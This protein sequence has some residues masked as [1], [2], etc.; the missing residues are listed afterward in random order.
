MLSSIRIHNLAVVAAAEL[1]FSNG[2]S[3]M[4]GETGA[5]KSILVDA[6]A[7]ALGARAEGRLVRTGAERAEVAAIFDR[8]SLP[9]DALNWLAEQD[10]DT[11]EDCVVRRTLTA[12]GRS[13]G[14]INGQ[15]VTM[16]SLREIGEKLVDICGQQAYLGLRHPAAQ[17]ELLDQFGGHQ[18]E[19]GK[20]AAGFDAWRRHQTALEDHDQ[21][22]RD[23]EQHMDLLSFQCQEL[24]G[25][26]LQTGEYAHLQREHRV[27]AASQRIEAGLGEVLSGLYEGESASAQD[28]LARCE[29][30]LSSLAETDPELAPTAG[31]LRDAGVLVSEAASAVRDQLNALEHDPEREEQIGQRLA[32]ARDLARK[33]RTEPEELPALLDELTEQLNKFSS[34]AEQR[35]QLV[36]QLAADA[37]ALKS[38][39]AKLSRARKKA[40][41]RLGKE[42]TAQMHDL[43]MPGGEFVVQLPARDSS[44]PSPHGAEGVAFQVTTNPGQ[45]PGPLAKVASG[46]EL[47]R[48]SLALQVAAVSGNHTG[49]LVFDEVDTGV[50]G[51]VAE[52][53]GQQLRALGQ[54]AQVL[55]VTH[56]PQ[57]ASQG[58]HHFLVS[59]QTKA[60]E[61]STA[62]EPLSPAQRVEELARM[63]GGLKIT[64][65]TREHAQEMLSA[66]K[67]RKA[68]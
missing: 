25:L 13:R 33:H 7:L 22:N 6:L 67:V 43:G 2:F 12:E 52:L 38:A 37:A 57:V 23:R 18:R 64:S 55:C 20:V 5:G 42:V 4:T 44:D 27:L 61:T 26:A 9:V 54:N 50:G 24:S 30:Q 17:R 32:D 39:A 62:V 47:S 21:A 48:L 56:L 46:G 49:T 59:K 65:R 35:E 41:T 45:A 11:D 40:A 29:H 51:R 31:L 1:E 15:P 66:A 28:I 34:S 58:N 36:E 16:Q 8:V 19:L 68:S 14:F 10:L 63:L 53:V 3:V 60:G